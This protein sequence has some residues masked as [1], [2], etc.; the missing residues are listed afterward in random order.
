[1]RVT[2]SKLRENVYQILDEAIATGVPV[3][4]VRKGKILKIVPDKPVSKLDRLKKQKGFVGDP[5][6]IVSMDWSK[7]WTE[8]K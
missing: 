7:E 6:D 5:E 4:V 3:E 1:M 2:A 8:L